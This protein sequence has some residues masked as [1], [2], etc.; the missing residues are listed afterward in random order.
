MQQWR[1]TETYTPD[2]RSQDRQRQF[3]D[4]SAPP[5]STGLKLMML[6]LTALGRDP[7]EFKAELD[8]WFESDEI[9]DFLSHSNDA[10]YY[11]ELSIR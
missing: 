7:L 11:W 4:F 1:I 6:G 9:Y 10:E 8:E 3:A 2:D 5:C